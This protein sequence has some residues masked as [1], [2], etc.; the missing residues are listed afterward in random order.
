MY[1]HMSGL[2]DVYFET[3]NTNLGKCWSALEWKMLIH[4]VAIWTMYCTD[5]WNMYLYST[6]IWSDV[7]TFGKFYDQLVHF[8]FI[9]YILSG[10]GIV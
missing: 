6:D 1:V 4:F 2:P 3:K 5:I 10:F 7:Q 8:V 9:W